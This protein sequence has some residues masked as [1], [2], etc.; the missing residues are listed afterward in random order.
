LAFNPFAF[1]DLRFFGLSLASAPLT[2]A[3]EA[4][5]TKR[6]LEHVSAKIHNERTEE[7][8]KRSQELIHPGSSPGLQAEPVFLSE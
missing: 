4:L 3:V 2:T 8:Q 7:L 6:E 5:L 1:V